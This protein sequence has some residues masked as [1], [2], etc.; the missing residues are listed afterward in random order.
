MDYAG[1][2]QQTYSL[3]KRFSLSL[4]RQEQF[5]FLVNCE[6]ANAYLRLSFI[7]NLLYSRFFGLCIDK[8][9]ALKRKQHDTYSKH[10]VLKFRLLHSYFHFI[11]L[12]SGSDKSETF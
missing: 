3:L 10:V 8:L 2:K 9:V 11:H 12:A 5:D 4:N 7:N 1:E 6:H